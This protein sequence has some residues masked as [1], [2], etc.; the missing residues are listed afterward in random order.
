MLSIL[1]HFTVTTYHS[2]MKDKIGSRV[3]VGENKA[4]LLTEWDPA[5]WR[6]SLRLGDFGI[7]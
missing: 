5:Q 3:S 6:V 4:L 2:R 1:R 7:F